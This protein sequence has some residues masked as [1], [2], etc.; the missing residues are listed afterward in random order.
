MV[1]Q[2]HDCTIRGLVLLQ[3][4]NRPASVPKKT[5]VMTN[6]THTRAPSAAEALTQLLAP[7]HELP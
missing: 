1:E 5:S 6:V 7:L 4:N 2:C 3:G